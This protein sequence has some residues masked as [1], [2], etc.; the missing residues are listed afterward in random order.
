[1]FVFEENGD[2]NNRNKLREFIGFDDDTESEQ[3]MKKKIYVE[4]H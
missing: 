1:M 3:F 4:K 2:R